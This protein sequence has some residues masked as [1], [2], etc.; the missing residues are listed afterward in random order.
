MKVFWALCI[1][2]DDVALKY[3]Q[4][5][6]LEATHLAPGSSSRLANR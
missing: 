1:L 5:K 6:I 4:F 3:V 2:C